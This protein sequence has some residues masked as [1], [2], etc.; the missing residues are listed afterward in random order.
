[1]PLLDIEPPPEA[2]TR[3]RG[4]GQGAIASTAPASEPCAGAAEPGQEQ[5]AGLA[6]HL[7]EQGRSA[8]KRW[9]RMRQVS[10]ALNEQLS[11][12]RQDLSRIETS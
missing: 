9:R 3:R 8:W 10:N 11:T 4:R 5:E 2:S 1:V 6:E 7:Q 12:S